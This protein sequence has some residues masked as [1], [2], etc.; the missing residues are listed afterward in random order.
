MSLFLKWLFPKL[1][2]PRFRVPGSKVTAVG[3][4][5]LYL[6]RSEIPDI[7]HWVKRLHKK[8]EDRIPLIKAD[9]RF[10]NPER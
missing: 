6:S 7:T 2:G 10:F 5:L 8:D 4:C 9:W 1:F 3:N